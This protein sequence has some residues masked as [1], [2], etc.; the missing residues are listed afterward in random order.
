VNEDARVG[1]QCDVGQKT[2]VETTSRHPRSVRD[3][4]PEIMRRP[5]FIFAH[6][7][8]AVLSAFTALAPPHEYALDIVACGGAP[9]IP[10]PG[11]WDRL[12][13]FASSAAAR[14]TRLAEQLRVCHDL[15]LAPGQLDLADG[16]Y[17]KQAAA[18][19]RTAVD[20]AEAMCR[21]ASCD[22]IVTHRPDAL[23]ADHQLTATV[24]NAVAGHLQIPV[25]RVCDRPYVECSSEGC[26]NVTGQGIRLNDLQ[27]HSKQRVIRIY[28]SQLGALTN[29]FGTD[30]SARHRLGW[31]CYEFGRQSAMEKRE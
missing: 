2:G 12:C 5:A 17:G 22:V 30:W 1:Y 24:A 9:G 27:W 19:V 13:G 4:I 29:A 3:I 23:H 28:M 16:Q 14:N 20:Q 31:E 15:G 8:D 7:D 21:Q 18:D 10:E 11:P 26:D 6:A 25:V